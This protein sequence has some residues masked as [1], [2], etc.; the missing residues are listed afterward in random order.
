MEDPVEGESTVGN[1]TDRGT[2]K[3][4]TKWVN[5]VSG[6][7]FYKSYGDKWIRTYTVFTSGDSVPSIIEGGL[8]DIYRRNQY[9]DSQGRLQDYSY[10]MKTRKAQCDTGDCANQYDCS[11]ANAAGEAGTS[12]AE[13]C[14]VCGDLL[15][16]Y[17]VSLVDG[18][19]LSIDIKPIGGTPNPNDPFSDVTRL[20]EPSIDLRSEGAIFENQPASKFFL[21]AKDTPSALVGA[22]ADPN[23]ILSVFSNCGYYEYP[24]APAGN[25]DPNTDEKCRLWRQFCCQSNL[26]GQPCKADSD[27]D[28]GGACWNGVCNCRSYYTCQNPGPPPPSTPID[29]LNSVP[30]P[31]GGPR[32][33][34]EELVC[35]PPETCFHSRDS[36]AQPIQGFCDRSKGECIGDD[37][38]HKYCHK[39]YSWPNDPTTFNSNAKDFVVTF[40]PNGTNYTNTRNVSTIPLCSSLDREFYYDANTAKAN[41]LPSVAN[42]YTC[43]VKRAIS[44]PSPPPWACTV[45]APGAS[46]QGVGTLCR[47]Q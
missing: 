46:C 11:Y 47:W 24:V 25:C 3:L 14:F 28:N 18:Y 23:R 32:L 22:G 43:A 17:D 1:G 13:F 8:G 16:Y 45:N 29:D 12:L 26:Y 31:D 10:Y 15:T 6:A 44:D 36:A 33:W 40:S 2:F 5:T 42:L 20:C 9:V 37:L 41:C 4:G 39:A 19:N 7:I 27:C 35:C 30:N 21:R 34:K 38:I